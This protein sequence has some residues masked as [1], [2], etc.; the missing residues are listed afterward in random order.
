MSQDP[1][2]LVWHMLCRENNFGFKRYFM[3]CVLAVL[4]LFDLPGSQGH[5][6]FQMSSQVY[7]II[8]LVRQ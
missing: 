4:D 2:R 5:C 7:K 8:T 1:G 6:Q 3:T